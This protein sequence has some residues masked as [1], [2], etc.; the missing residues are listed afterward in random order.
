MIVMETANQQNSQHIQYL[1]V[2]Q[3]LFSVLYIDQFISPAQQAFEVATTLSSFTSEATKAQRVVQFCLRLH[4]A[5]TGREER[6]CSFQRLSLEDS[7]PTR[8]ESFSSLYPQL[9]VQ[10]AKKIFLKRRGETKLIKGSDCEYSI[11]ATSGACFI[12]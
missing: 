5:I 12:L 6:L 11:L 3:M 9:K 2:H 1:T 7:F 8:T 4:N 10:K